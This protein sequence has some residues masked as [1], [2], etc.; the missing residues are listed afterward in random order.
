MKVYDKSKYSLHDV[1]IIDL[2]YD[3]YKNELSLI[4]D[5]GIMT[6]GEKKQTDFDLA[7]GGVGLDDSYVYILD[8]KNV[9]AGNKG[10][11]VGEKLGLLDLI[12][13]YDSKFKKIDI[14]SDL[15]SYREVLLIGYIQRGQEI[16]EIFIDIYYDGKIYLE[17]KKF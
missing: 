5:Y 8:Y 3:F 15:H 10:A 14:V 13:S 4:T 12:T 17:G 6:I 11:F 1:A 9:L 16:L 2:D 7:I